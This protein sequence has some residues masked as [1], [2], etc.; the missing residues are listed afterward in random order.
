[1]DG[2]VP[3]ASDVIISIHPG[4]ADAILDGTKTIELRRRIPELANGTRLWIYATRP[5][6]AV[7]GVATIADVNRAHP[8]KIWEKY[9]KS[10]GV[11]HASFKAYFDGAQEAVA[12]LL[13]A[14]KRIGPITV[15]Q[16]REIRAGFHPPQVLL[17]LTD[18]Q[19]RALQKLADRPSQGKER[20]LEPP[21]RISS[22]QVSVLGKPRFRAGG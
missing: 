10:A 20:W 2:Q 11:D 22:G 16:L 8:S 14:V 7:V 6:A 13:G 9:K 4:Y 18:A 17:R 19:A 12:I 5:T 15:E 21:N 1:V 3:D